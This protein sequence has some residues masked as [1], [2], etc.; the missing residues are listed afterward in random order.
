MQVLK[1]KEKINISD[2][3]ALFLNRRENTPHSPRYVTEKDTGLH[4]NRFGN[5]PP[6][7]ADWRGEDTVDPIFHEILLS[8]FTVAAGH[9]TGV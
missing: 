6:L 8:C 7:R 1:G 9:H 5:P 3:I 4:P 2:E